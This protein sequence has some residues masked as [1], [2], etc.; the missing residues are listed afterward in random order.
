MKINTLDRELYEISERLSLIRKNE[1]SKYYEEI[2]EST[3]KLRDLKKKSENEPDEQN[4]SDKKEMRVLEERTKN[5][6]LQIK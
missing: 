3:R 1:C 6:E 2:Q 5:C 4:E